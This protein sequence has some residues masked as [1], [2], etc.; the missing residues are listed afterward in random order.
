MKPYT[1][2]TT[3]RKSDIENAIKDSKGFISTIAKKLNCDW[4]TAKKA[5]ETHQ[6]DEMLQN[7]KET[8]TDFVES[9]L[10]QNINDN[11]VTSIIF[12][13]K[14]QAKKRGYVDK[15]EVQVEG[16]ITNINITS[17]DEAKAINQALENDY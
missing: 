12:Y 17:A 15:T 11:D 14:T 5:I 3:I 1:K 2:I 9:K 4:H 7:E 13:L 6:L 16:K 8:L 10:I